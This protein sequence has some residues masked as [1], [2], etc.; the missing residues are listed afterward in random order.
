MTRQGDQVRK[1]RRFLFVGTP[2]VIGVL[3]FLLGL[4]G[5]DD[6]LRTWR[7]WIVTAT[8]MSP[9]TFGSL[10][11]AA[12][13]LIILFA[14]I[15]ALQFWQRDRSA[16]VL[17]T[18]DQEPSE[19]I[20]PDPEDEDARAHRARR[21]RINELE[22]KRLEHQYSSGPQLLTIIRN[23]ALDTIQDLEKLKT[24]P[25]SRQ[26]SFSASIESRRRDLRRI[27]VDWKDQTKR[28]VVRVYGEQARH[29]YEKDET[30]PPHDP[31]G[32][33]TTAADEEAL[34]YTDVWNRLWRL[35]VLLENDPKARRQ[36]LPVR[37]RV[38]DS[39][40][41]TVVK[42]EDNTSV[43]PSARIRH[44]PGCRV[45]LEV[46]KLNNPDGS[47]DRVTRCTAC[48]E[49]MRDDFAHR[50]AEFG[51]EDW[52]VWHRQERPEEGLIQDPQWL[53]PRIELYVRSLDGDKQ[54]L[55]RCDVNGPEPSGGR[56]TWSVDLTK[57]VFLGA[58]KG[59]E[60]I[61]TLGKAAQIDPMDELELDFPTQFPGTPTLLEPG[62]YDVIWWALEGVG[63]KLVK[64]DQFTIENG[65][66]VA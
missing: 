8:S 52:A 9:E 13:F 30:L 62:K 4:P 49:Q 57:N 23:L 11:V 29:L 18:S 39:V 7:S 24:A 63:N 59:P 12:G 6:D 31:P 41:A 43:P 47:W 35:H 64:F 14:N 15:P 51:L 3:L 54:H 55:Y 17:E 26:A 22:T 44:T 1:K 42:A 19:A 25:Y 20:F 60:S 21:Q 50:S 32:F 33:D 34:L 58:A 40:T 46:L 28:L 66:L 48:G 36:P 56:V 61:T 45:E 37:E 38:M 16:D 27:V 5:Y 10:L 53:K 65:N 2:T